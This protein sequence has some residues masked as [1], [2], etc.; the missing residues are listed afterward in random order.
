MQ[1]NIRQHN[2][3]ARLSYRIE[4]CDFYVRSRVVHRPAVLKFHMLVHPRRRH[5]RRNEFVSE[6]Q[7][8]P[9]CP[10]PIF[11]T[12]LLISLNDLERR[13]SPYFAFFFTECDRFSA[14]CLKIN[15]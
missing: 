13:N 5:S 7:S 11:K 2:S 1:N 10:H 8:M 12:T 14:Q 9:L 15:L 3:P 4:V 6:G